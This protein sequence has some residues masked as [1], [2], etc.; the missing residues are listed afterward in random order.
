MNIT[1]KDTKTAIANLQQFLYILMKNELPTGKVVE[2]INFI[3][4][5]KDVEEIKYS[6]EE[7]AEYAR[8]LAIKL[9]E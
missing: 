6:L 1:D 8:K 4:E 5:T 7:L 2:I 3:E 9:I